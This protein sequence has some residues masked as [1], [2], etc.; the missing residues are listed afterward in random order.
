M[1]YLTEEKFDRTIKKYL[2]EE[3][4]DKFKQ[5]EFAGFRKEFDDFIE[6]PFANLVVKTEKIEN[7]LKNFQEDVRFEFGQMNARM[8]RIEQT[9]DNKFNT[10]IN[11]IDGFLRRIDIVGTETTMAH[12]RIDRIEQHIGFSI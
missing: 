5:G 8:D 3:K 12:V 9:M 11:M 6:G 1:G 2:T 10:I 7:D 4:F